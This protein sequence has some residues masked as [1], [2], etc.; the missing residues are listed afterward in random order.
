VPRFWPIAICQLLF[1]FLWQFRNQPNL[2]EAG[3][4]ENFGNYG[5]PGDH[6]NSPYLLQNTPNPVLDRNTL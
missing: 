4:V 2:K 5:N 6:G 1:A 3:Q